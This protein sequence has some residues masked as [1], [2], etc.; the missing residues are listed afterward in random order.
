M[1]IR[2]GLWQEKVMNLLVL[3]LGLVLTLGGLLLVGAQVNKHQIKPN[4]S[5]AWIW[6][7]GVLLLFITACLL[8]KDSQINQVIRILGAMQIAASL[9][10]VNHEWV[11]SGDLHL[12]SYQFKP[13]LDM[14]IFFFSAFLGNIGLLIGLAQ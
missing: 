3:L 12:G 8:E 6:R 9:I 1:F 14:L 2:D 11:Q 7:G 10:I 13:T 5:A 4:S